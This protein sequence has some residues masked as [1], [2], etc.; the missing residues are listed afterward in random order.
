MTLRIL[1]TDVK[2]LSQVVLLPPLS[3]TRVFGP[4]DRTRL[5][6]GLQGLWEFREDCLPNPLSRVRLYSLFF[7]HSYV[8]YYGIFFYIFPW[9][10]KDCFFWVVCYSSVSSPFNFGMKNECDFLRITSILLFQVSSLNLWVPRWLVSCPQHHFVRTVLSLF[11]TL[12]FLKFL[13]FL[14]LILRYSCTIFICCG[15]RVILRTS[16]L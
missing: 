8:C 14:L 13:I 7:H 1:Y 2:L 3:G 9:R 6:Q 12:F 10:C 11:F 16:Y 15:F 5:P 4:F